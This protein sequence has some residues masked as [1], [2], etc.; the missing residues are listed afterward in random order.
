MDMAVNK[1]MTAFETRA[2][3]FTVYLIPAEAPPLQR[4]C[5]YHRGPNPKALF[6]VRGF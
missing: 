2:K 5:G 6:K 3:H 4:P 1:V